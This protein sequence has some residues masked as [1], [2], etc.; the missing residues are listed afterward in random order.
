MRLVPQ[1]QAMERVLQ[2]LGYVESDMQLT[3]KGKAAVEML[4]AD[5]LTL[6]E[7]IFENV[8]HESLDIPTVVAVVAAFVAGN[9]GTPELDFNVAKRALPS[10]VVAVLHEVA[11][12][13]R[14]V[15]EKQLKE[16][17]VQI[18][19]EEF[20]KQV[21][22]G[23][24]CAAYQWASGR[25]FSEIMADQD[26]VCPDGDKQ[27]QEGSI[28]R[29]MVRTDEL[30]RKACVAMDVIGSKAL[31]EKLEACREAI[32]RDIAFAMSLYIRGN[33]ED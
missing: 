24:S 13:H 16:E 17:R 33:E 23:A 18:V 30:L 29:I 7:I 20:D 27:L 21:C 1:R 9:D 28:A 15:V 8:L 4:N 22:F 5:E 26:C 14:E 19:W 6:A 25:S 31:K 3:F 32:R 11:K 2:K 12:I 10:T